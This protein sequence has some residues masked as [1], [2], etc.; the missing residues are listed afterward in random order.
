MLVC[1]YFYD[2][3]TCSEMQS[4]SVSVYAYGFIL[5]LAPQDVGFAQFREETLGK[6][7]NNP[8]ESTRKV[9]ENPE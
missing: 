3:A 4:E 6:C 1:H 5:S 7:N 9:L 2:N 8:E